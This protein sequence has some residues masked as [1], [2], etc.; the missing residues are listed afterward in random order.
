MA[1]RDSS[2]SSAAA[3]GGGSGVEASGSAAGVLGVAAGT[4]VP[5]GDVFKP[6][7]SPRQRMPLADPTASFPVASFPVASSSGDIGGG[8]GLPV[9]R[10]GRP[11]CDGGGGGGSGADGRVPGGGVAGGGTGARFSG[12]RPGEVESVESIAESKFDI[13]TSSRKL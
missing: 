7:S 4:G 5:A 9:A 8:A 13:G 2:A 3:G 12:G 6:S 10:D 1:S 11:A